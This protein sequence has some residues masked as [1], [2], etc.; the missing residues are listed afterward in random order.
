MKI[1]F[2]EENAGEKSITRLAFAFLIG[3]AILA[4]GFIFVTNPDEYASGLAVFAAIAGVATGLKL[5]QKQQESDERKT[6]A[7]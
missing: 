3:Y 1:G 2:F 6:V 5:I 4:S 7:N